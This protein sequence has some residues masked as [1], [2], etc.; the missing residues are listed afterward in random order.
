MKI[1]DVSS[2]HIVIIGGILRLVFAPHVLPPVIVGLFVFLLIFSLRALDIF[3]FAEEQHVNGDLAVIV[4]DLHAL[5]DGTLDVHIADHE[6]IIEQFSFAATLEI[7]PLVGWEKAWDASRRE[8]CLVEIFD[9]GVVIVEHL[10]FAC[11]NVHS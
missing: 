8:S 11:L 4:D 6:V 7:L 5:V 2:A 10:H 9:G 1:T 3:H